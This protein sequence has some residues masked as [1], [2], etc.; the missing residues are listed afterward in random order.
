MQSLQKSESRYT[1]FP[2]IS[3]KAGV[4]SYLFSLLVKCQCFV[5]IMTN[6]LKTFGFLEKIRLTIK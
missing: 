6:L 5:I 1:K 3:F 4:G 2:I